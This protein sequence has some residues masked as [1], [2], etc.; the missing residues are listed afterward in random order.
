MRL[1]RLRV[2]P[3][4][5]VVHREHHV[6]AG[7]QALVLRWRAPSSSV[8]VRRLDRRACRPRHRVARVDD[9]VH[10]HL[11][12]LP[13]VGLHAAE[14]PARSIVTSSMSSPIRRRS[15]LSISP[16]TSFRSSDPRLQDLLAAEREELARQRGCAR[17]A[18]LAISSMSVC[19]PGS[20]V[21]DARSSSEL[22]VAEDHGQQ[23]VE[24]V[25]DAAGE[26]ADGLHLLR[27]AELALEADALLLGLF[28]RRDV[29]EH[30]DRE[31]RLREC[32]AHE[33]DGVV[34]PDDLSALREHAL[35]EPVLLALARGEL[36]E[37][38]E[39]AAAVIWMRELE[40]A[41]ARRA[42][43]CRSRRS[44]RARGCS[45]RSALRGR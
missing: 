17:S 15:I 25:R 5:G 13:R 26:L 24:V 23:V 38:L 41:Q 34:G 27:L 31:L 45:S 8:D 6:A 43:P 32:V 1:R 2:H 40:G 37:Q 10:D 11:L 9:E 39:L 22:A 36:A 30:R 7:A 35:L 44:A 29:L 19:D 20:P 16:T 33:R 21:A 3:V 4:A 42:R 18:A 14:R 12:D 28:A